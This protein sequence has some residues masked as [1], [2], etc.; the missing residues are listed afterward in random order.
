[1]AEAY[2]FHNESK[3]KRGQSVKAANNITAFLQWQ[4]VETS[5]GTLN[6]AMEAYDAAKAEAEAKAAVE[7]V[8]QA[9]AN[10]AVAEAA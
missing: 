4:A 10:T 3:F 7:A 6:A 5:K 9:M 2:V 1:M 8:A